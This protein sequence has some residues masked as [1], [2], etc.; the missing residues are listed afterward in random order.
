[1]KKQKIA[2]SRNDQW[3]GGHFMDLLI[4]HDSSV[5]K[6]SFNQLNQPKKLSSYE[7]ENSVKEEELETIDHVDDI[8]KE[9]I[10][11]DSCKDP[12]GN[13]DANIEPISE[14]LSPHSS[15]HLEND[16][17]YQFS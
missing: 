9:P 14:Y 6:T 5:D 15:A 12:F 4:D 13:C 11:Q 3:K 16:Q 17:D 7:I 1:M 8:K 2:E 10:D